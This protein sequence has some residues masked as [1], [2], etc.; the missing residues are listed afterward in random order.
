MGM[1]QLDRAAK[2]SNG[3][4]G[5]SN[6]LFAMLIEVAFFLVHSL[7]IVIVC[8]VVRHVLEII[9]ASNAFLL[10]QPSMLSFY[11]HFPV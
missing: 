11:C 4:K 3:S 8:F 6:P 1:A 10:T 9:F 2:L 5:R 7:G